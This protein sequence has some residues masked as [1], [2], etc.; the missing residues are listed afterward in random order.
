MPVSAGGGAS[1]GT[2]G[3]AAA[4]ACGGL[5]VAS[6]DGGA[7]PSLEDGE[8]EEEEAAAGAGASSAANG[9]WCTSPSPPV[10]LALA[11]AAAAVPG[12]GAKPYTA[13]TRQMSAHPQHSPNTSLFPLQS[14]K[15][16]L[17][18]LTAE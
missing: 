3:R 18:L 11:A 1:L 6:Y 16:Q 10:V 17:Q 5:R 8:A 4:P 13:H 15:K 14:I 12:A 2:A 9:S 7:S